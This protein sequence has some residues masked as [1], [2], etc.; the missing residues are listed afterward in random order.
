MVIHSE[1]L[2]HPYIWIFAIV[3]Y[4]CFYSVQFFAVIFPDWLCNASYHGNNASGIGGFSWNY[5]SRAGN[6]EQK[7]K[8]T[9]INIRKLTR[10]NIKSLFLFYFQ[11]EC[12]ILVRPYISKLTLSEIHALMTVGLAGVSGTML[13]AYISLGVRSRVFI[14]LK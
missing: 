5:I 11:A 1:T 14:C 4:Y 8:T 2:W 3:S 13:A 10:C 9:E 7:I 6:Q 12:L